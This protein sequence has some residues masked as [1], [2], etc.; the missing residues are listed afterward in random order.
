[1]HLSFIQNIKEKIVMASGFLSVYMLTQK[2]DVISGE[3]MFMTF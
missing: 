3:D 2:T 1:M